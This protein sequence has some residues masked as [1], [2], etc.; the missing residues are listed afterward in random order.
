MFCYNCGK[1]KSLMNIYSVCQINWR[2][3]LSDQCSNLQIY[4][5][6]YHSCWKW[7]LVSLAPWWWILLSDHGRIGSQSARTRAKRQAHTPSRFFVVFVLKNKNLV[8]F[9]SW[10]WILLS[11]HGRIESQPARTRAKRQA[12]TPSC[13]FVAFVLKNKNLVFFVSWWRN[14]W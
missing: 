7:N 12:H 4:P 5:P 9:V 8:F 13:F 10:W 6:S 14:T 1:S 11:D 3:L 2:E